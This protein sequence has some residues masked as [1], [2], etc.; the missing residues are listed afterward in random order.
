MKG[1]LKRFT[2]FY[3]GHVAII[4]SLVISGYWILANSFNVYTYP[5]VGAIYELLWVFMIPLLFL[6]PIASLL[7]IIMSN[8]KE[9]YFYILSILLN[10]GTFIW[11]KYYL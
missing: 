9:S 1:E 11:M 5:F 2:N 6:V 4:S 10:S 3:T 8:F 7:G